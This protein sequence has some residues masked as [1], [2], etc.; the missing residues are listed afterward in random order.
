[1][2][3]FN[4]LDFRISEGAIAKVRRVLWWLDK[5]W[6]V[7][8]YAMLFT[9]AYDIRV[10][11]ELWATAFEKPNMSNPAVLDAPQINFSNYH[12]KNESQSAAVPNFWVPEKKPDW[13]AKIDNNATYK[14]W[15]EVSKFPVGPWTFFTFV[16]LGLSGWVKSKRLQNLTSE[17]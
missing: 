15:Y 14:H 3:F 7:V 11:P 5:A 13:T 6:L 8:T 1:M 12:F 4:L 17:A 16:L 10:H 9:L 2:T